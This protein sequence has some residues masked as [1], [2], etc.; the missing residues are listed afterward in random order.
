MATGDKAAIATFNN[1]RARLVTA[2]DKY[3][4]GYAVSGTI[5]SG[6]KMTASTLNTLLSQCTAVSAK[7]P[8][9]YSFGSVSVGALISETILNTAYT[10]I[11]NVANCYSNCHSNCHSN[12]RCNCNVNCG[13]SPD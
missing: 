7:S 4:S 9:V 12:C 2:R 11:N 5:T 10:N 8:L 6:T 13:R 3:Y 1:I